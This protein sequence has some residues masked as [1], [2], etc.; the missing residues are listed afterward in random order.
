VT[1]RDEINAALAVFVDA[2]P[3]TPRG[4]LAPG[5]SKRRDKK[6]PRPKRVNRHIGTPAT[7]EVLAALDAIRTKLRKHAPGI[8][9]S[10]TTNSAIL[11]SALLA[12]A[13]DLTN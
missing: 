5:G 7:P 9:S 13:R 3:A 2:K 4:I 8:V 1:T 6:Q 10:F 12:Y 11:R